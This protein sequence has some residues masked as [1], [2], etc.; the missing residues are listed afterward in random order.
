LAKNTIIKNTHDKKEKIMKKLLPILM[1]IFTLIAC[2]EKDVQLPIETTQ[3]ESVKNDIKACENDIKTC[4]NGKN[5]S[6]NLKNNCEFDACQVSVVK[7]IKKE[8]VMCTADVKECA[9]GSFVG[10]DHY[11]NCKFKDC[12]NGEITKLKM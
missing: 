3:S 9:D 2:Q 11:N 6:R 7:P 4:P 1:A 8:P 10:R 5:V 12:P